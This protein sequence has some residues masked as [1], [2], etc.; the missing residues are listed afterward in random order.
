MRTGKSDETTI[1]I[2]NE[3]GQTVRTLTGETSSGRHTAIWD[4][5]NEAGIDQPDG[6]YGFL[7]SA[8][9]QD[10]EDVPVGQGT[11]GDVSWGHRG[12]NN[13]G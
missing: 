6:I 4:G 12:T 11:V 5:K 1:T 3:D 2:V 13:A 8:V 9:D 10:G 7:V